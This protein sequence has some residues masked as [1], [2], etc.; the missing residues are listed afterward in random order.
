MIDTRVYAKPGCFQGHTDG[1]VAK[2]C[3]NSTLPIIYTEKS[4][5]QE[6]TNR[7]P[8]EARINGA[9]GPL[10]NILAATSWCYVS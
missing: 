7:S 2:I 1:L 8:Q 9:I 5:L 3:A 6:E 4:D 10:E